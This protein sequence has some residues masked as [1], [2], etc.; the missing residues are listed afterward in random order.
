M[1]W[2]PDGEKIPKICL[3]VLTECTNVTDTQTNRRQTPHDDIG[4]AC[5]ASRGKNRQHMRMLTISSL[6]LR[7]GVISGILCD[8]ITQLNWEF[9]SQFSKFVMYPEKNIR[10]YAPHCRIPFWLYQNLQKCQAITR[11]NIPAYYY[12]GK[13]NRLTVE[14]S[15]LSLSLEL[16]KLYYYYFCKF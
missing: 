8:F 12:T 7:H 1:T 3:F 15:T 13:Q 5:I 6:R 14:Q 9:I 16:F 10:R 4:R 11:A 2:L